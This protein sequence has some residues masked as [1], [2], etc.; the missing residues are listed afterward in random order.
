MSVSIEFHG[1]NTGVYLV[2]TML[3]NSVPIGDGSIIREMSAKFPPGKFFPAEEMGGAGMFV[4]ATYGANGGLVPV[5]YEGSS[6]DLAEALVNAEKQVRGE[7]V[8]QPYIFDPNARRFLVQGGNLIGWQNFMLTSPSLGAVGT[9]GAGMQND[10]RGVSIVSSG[11]GT[12]SGPGSLGSFAESVDSVLSKVD[13]LW[14][15][16]GMSPDTSRALTI[17]GAVGI[18]ALVGVAATAGIVP[19]LIAGAAS[20]FGGFGLSAAMSYTVKASA[21]PGVLE[22]F[23]LAVNGQDTSQCSGLFTG[24]SAILGTTIR[25]A[26]K[27]GGS[28]V[29]GASE[30]LK[31]L[32]RMKKYGDRIA[33]KWKNALWWGLGI[34]AASLLTYG[35]IRTRRS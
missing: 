28:I 23:N 13:G 3:D 25:G 18:A 33:G 24:T 10:G 7:Q 35:Y 30:V 1:G 6:I 20:F 4:P 8:S 5:D 19:G 2:E 12:L 32:Q 29:G 11:N 14:G 26:Q 34:S 27:I 31:A 9:I 16:M 21:V 22:C 17:G 15:A